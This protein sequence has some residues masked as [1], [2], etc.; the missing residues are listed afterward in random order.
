MTDVQFLNQ[1]ERFV[2]QLNATTADYLVKK[3]PNTEHQI[4][5][6]I[7]SAKLAPYNI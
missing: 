3:S 6:C 5:I 7:M 1:N 2:D 4:K